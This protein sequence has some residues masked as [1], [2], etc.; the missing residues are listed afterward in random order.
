MAADVEKAEGT[1]AKLDRKMHAAAEHF[2]RETDLLRAA[3]RYRDLIHSLSR[4]GSAHDEAGEFRRRRGPLLSRRTWPAPRWMIRREPGN[5]PKKR[6]LPQKLPASG[7]Y[8]D[9]S[10]F[11]RR[12]ILHRPPR[13]QIGLLPLRNPGT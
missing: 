9:D 7:A 13:E 4:S 10:P 12:D 6:S 3:H 5:L 2:D 8:F 11:D 1:V